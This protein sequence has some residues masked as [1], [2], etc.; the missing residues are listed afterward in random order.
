MRACDAAMLV[1]HAVSASAISG[2]MSSHP[3]LS[4]KQGL[5]IARD[6]RVIHRESSREKKKKEAEFAPVSSYLPK[7]QN[8]TNSE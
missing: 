8:S 2:I 5:L 1:K 6:Y 3:D 7:K 4:I